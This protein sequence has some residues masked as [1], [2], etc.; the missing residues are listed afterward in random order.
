MQYN[1]TVSCTFLPFIQPV[2]VI[3][4]NW[5]VL[6]DFFRKMTAQTFHRYDQFMIWII[7]KFGSFTGRISDIYYSIIAFYTV[8]NLI[9]YH[10]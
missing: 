8:R 4:D 2:V 5:L 6:G 10:L 7:T 1:R 9:K 3:S